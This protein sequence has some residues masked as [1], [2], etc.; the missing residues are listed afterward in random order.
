MNEKI[1]ELALEFKDYKLALSAVM[2]LVGNEHNTS[3]LNL[4]SYA[5]SYVHS[6]PCNTNITYDVE[7]VR[8]VQLKKRLND[9]MKQRKE[10][11]KKETMYMEKATD[12]HTCRNTVLHW[13]LN[14]LEQLAMYHRAV[15][16]LQACS[17]ATDVR[18][19]VKQHLQAAKDG[20]FYRN[21][22]GC[23]PLIRNGLDIYH[24]MSVLGALPEQ[25]PNHSVQ[26]C[27]VQNM[28]KVLSE[29]NYWNVLDVLPDVEHTLRN[30]ASM[31]YNLARYCAEQDQQLWPDTATLVSG[32]HNAAMSKC[33]KS[34]AE[35]DEYV[36]A[37]NDFRKPSLSVWPY[38]VTNSLTNHLH[39]CISEL[40]G[41]ELSQI[42]HRN[43]VK[44]WQESNEKVTVAVTKYENVVSQLQTSVQN[45][46][47]VHDLYKDVMKH[48]H[49][50]DNKGLEM[51]TWWTIVENVLQELNPVIF[52]KITQCKDRDILMEEILKHEMEGVTVR[53]AS[54]TR[55]CRTFGLLFA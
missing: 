21:A 14:D 26:T 1:S 8:N 48:C 17:P 18:E 52:S 10:P 38:E 54:Y 6:L 29:V 46:A 16:S 33:F 50:K 12:F 43:V 7:S 9:F 27:I 2:N 41:R 5:V 3:D 23:G 40:A 44:P 42:W 28:V 15:C 49:S 47:F 30:L 32:M 35:V 55:L 11:S 25:N 39:R 37:L 36:K 51:D 53:C 4:V 31:A 34:N 19:R 45:K 13:K 20:Q 24:Y 22:I